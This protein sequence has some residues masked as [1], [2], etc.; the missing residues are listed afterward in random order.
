MTRGEEGFAGGLEGLVFGLLVFVVGTLLVANAWGVVDTKLAA[1]AAAQ[2]AVR[3]YVEAPGAAVAGAEATAAAD[4][5][6]AGYGR[7]PARARV[8]L[9]SGHFARCAEVTIG[10]SYQAPLVELPLLGVVGSGEAVT[11]SRSEIVDPYR[12]GLAGRAACG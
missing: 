10:V 4:Q 11:A 1:D 8:T 5:A 7:D 3:T 9:V 2:Q 12:S 6:L